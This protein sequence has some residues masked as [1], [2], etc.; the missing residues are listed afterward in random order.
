WL[1]DLL[2]ELGVELIL[3]HATRL[4]AIA[5][6][7]VKTDRLDS[8]LLAQLLR[9][10]LIPVA[11]RIARD[12]RGPRDLMRLRVRLVEKK[13]SCLNSLERIREKCHVVNRDQ[14]DQ[15][16]QHQ[17]D[18]YDAQLVLLTQQTHDLEGMLHPLLIPNADVQ[19]LLWIPGIGKVNEFTIWTEIDGIERFP[20]EKQFLSYCRLVP[21]AD[22]S[23]GRTRHRSG[24]KACNRYLKLAFGHASVR[25]IQYFPVIKRFYHQQR[26]RKPVVVAR[27][28]VAAELGRIVYQ[29]L[30]KQQ[31]FNGMFRGVPLQHT[32]TRQWPRLANPAA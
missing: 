13:I 6:A 21:G 12:A 2:D 27:A 17:V 16:Y 9:A 10:G 7:K 32:K 26:R 30:S 29:V 1:A 5:A 24:A 25:A 19:R 14:L 23:G 4:K 22:N 18:V 3:A 11:H 28:I 15:W 20:T 8:D 31:D